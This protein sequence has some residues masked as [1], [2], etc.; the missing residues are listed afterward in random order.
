[1]VVGRRLS[2]GGLAVPTGRAGPGIRGAVGRIPTNRLTAVRLMVAGRTRSLGVVLARVRR[3][4][5]GGSGAAGLILTN[6]LTARP[7]WGQMSR[8]A[9][10]VRMRRAALGGSGAVGLMPTSWLTGRPAWGRMSLGAGLVR[11]S[12]AELGGS[13]VV[14]P[15]LTI[16]RMGRGRLAG[17][18]PGPGAAM[19][20]TRRAGLAVGR[21]PMSWRT[22]QSPA[23]VGWPSRGGLAVAVRLRRPG[24]SGAGVARRRIRRLAAD[25]AP[26]SRASHRV[27]G[28]AGRPGP[29]STSA[30]TRNPVPR[31]GSA[32]TAASMSPP[33]AAERTD[34]RPGRWRRPR[35]AHGSAAVLSGGAR[36]TTLAMGLT[37]RWPAQP[38]RTPSRPASPPSPRAETRSWPSS[39]RATR[40]ASSPRPRTTVGP[41]TRRPPAGCPMLAASLDRAGVP[42]RPMPSARP[43]DPVR[44]W[45]PVRG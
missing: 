7:G 44:P 24:I 41:G 8:G 28:E 2:R 6:W 1:M 25:L 14:G 40:A 10:L 34:P 36:P 26:P 15:R 30:G 37:G 33:P 35:R 20:P 39:R 21:R 11:M 17:D 12:R 45:V 27:D 23:A 18:R 19:L 29:T 13:G 16:R 31:S 22:A 32:R 42:S 38:P 9:G 4:G 5:L 3:P 43:R